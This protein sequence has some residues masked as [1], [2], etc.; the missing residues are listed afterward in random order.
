MP[1]ADVNGV[2]LHYQDRGSGLPV[3][4]LHGF[5]LSSDSF[6]PQLEALSGRFRIIAPDH[7][8]FGG[9]PAS[10][11]GTPLEMS[12]IARDALALLDQLGV[13][14]AVVGGVSMGGYAAMALLREDA[15]RVLGL[16]LIDTQPGAD[17]EAGR[18]GREETAQAIGKLGVAVLVERMLPKLLSPEAAPALRAQTDRLIRTATAEGAADASRGMALRSDSKDVLARFAGPALVVVGERD[19]ITPVEKARAMK[20]LIGGAELVV[21]PGAGHL[22]N[23]EAPVAFNREIESFLNRLPPS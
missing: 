6:A 17:D 11:G 2:K 23:L 5:P 20:E 12:Q 15:G 7:R 19:V 14:R 21:I 18:K 3:L 9:T 10:P 4:L 1:I 22:S 13:E 16:L 8:G